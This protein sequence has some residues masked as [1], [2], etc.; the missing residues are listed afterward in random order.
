MSI[1]GLIFDLDGVICS[2]DLYHYLSWKKLADKLGVYFDTEI[3]ERLR[4]VSRLESLEIILEKSNKL[5]TEEEKSKMAEEKNKYYQTFLKKMTTNDVSKEVLDTLQILRERGY[6]LAIGSSS[7]NAKIILKQI[8][9][10]DFFDVIADGTMIKYSKPHPEIFIE[11]SKGL[12]IQPKECAVIED[13]ESG[14]IAAK[15]ASMKVAG[16]SSEAKCIFADYHL[17]EFKEL[18]DIFK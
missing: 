17:S 10:I 1:K 15:S 14:C 11:A 16:I 8:G 4:G 3:N 18:L 2:T 9:L 5:Y 12:N 7:K 13:S 6:K